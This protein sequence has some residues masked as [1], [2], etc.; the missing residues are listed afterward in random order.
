MYKHVHIHT[1]MQRYERKSDMRACVWWRSL[2]VFFAVYSGIVNNQNFSRYVRFNALQSILLDI[3][4]MCALLRPL[5]PL[6]C[7]PGADA[8]LRRAPFYVCP[9]T[10][11]H[12]FSWVACCTAIEMGTCQ[13]ARFHLLKTPKACNAKPGVCCCALHSVPG[14]LEQVLRP[15]MSGPF[16]S[17]YIQVYNAIFV[18]VFFS[19]LYAVVRAQQSCS[20]AFLH[21]GT[22][23]HVLLL[24]NLQMVCD[25]TVEVLVNSSITN[26][27]LAVSRHRNPPDGLVVKVRRW[28]AQARCAPC[29]Q[30]SC[31]FGETP[32]VPLVADAA[33][34]QVR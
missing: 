29:V 21:S 32:R 13:V 24:L 22:V 34:Q 8:V 11:Q 31:L 14:L 9:T 23:V 18:F 20:L 1:Y 6:L 27:N 33:D 16:L 2:I 28:S 17:A 3:I 26:R 15:P 10:R 30:G 7:S 19:V 12:V 4:L 25:I 5:S